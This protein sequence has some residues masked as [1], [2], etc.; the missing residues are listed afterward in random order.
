MMAG[1]HVVVGVV[2]WAWA[3]PHLGFPAL[4]PVALALAIGGALLPDID[5][6]HSWVGRRARLISDPLATMIGHRGLNPPDSRTLSWPRSPVVCC[7]A[8]GA[9]DALS[10]TLWWSA[11]CR[12]S[13][14]TS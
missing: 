3:A 2:A 8:G 12:T 10:R 7:S 6:P 13:R 1:S 11:I 14:W 4:D 9:W 5:H